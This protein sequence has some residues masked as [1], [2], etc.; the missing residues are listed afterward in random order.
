MREERSEREMKRRG[1]G[2]E[3]EGGGGRRE[4]GG[5]DER[6]EVISKG[7]TSKHGD[8]SFCP[9]QRGCPLLEAKMYCHY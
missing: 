7:G 6:E 8:G 9:L 2:G 1:E 3:R 4:R 5:G